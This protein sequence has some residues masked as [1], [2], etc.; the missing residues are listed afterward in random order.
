MPLHETAE[1]IHV[2]G[3]VQGVGF[4]PTVWRLAHRH[5]IRGTVSNDGQGVTIHACGPAAALDAL[6]EAIRREMPPLARIDSIERTAVTRMPPGPA[7]QIGPSQHDQV[8][9]G[10]V[11]DAATCTVCLAEVR[12][13]LE[14]RFGY[15]F[16]NCIHCG[17][18]LSI[19]ES[20]P[21]DR[22]GT[23]MRRFP[24]CG[25]CRA[26]YLDPGDRRFHAQPTACPVC[27][28]RAWLEP[29]RGAAFAFDDLAGLGSVHSLDSPDSPDSLSAGHAADTM[30]AACTVLLR[31]AVLAIKG[32]GGFQ[33]ACDATNE[34]AVARLRSVK[35]RASKPLALLARDLATIK[36]Y[37]HVDPA[38]AKL[39][40]SP[41][42]P[43]VILS[44]NDAVAAGLGLGLGLGLAP[45]CALAPAVAP[46]VRSLGFMLPSTPLHHLLLERIDRPIVLTSGN[47]SEEPQCIANDEARERLRDLTDYL[48]LHDRDIA[49]RL[50][51]SVARVMAGEVRV[52]R[53]ARGYAPAPLAL[54]PGFEATPPVLAM[55]GELKNT[56]CLVRRGQAIVSHHMG[57]LAE[58]RTH[59]DYVEAIG[60]Y[61]ELFAQPA[62][63]VAVDLHPEYRSRALGVALAKR[64]GAALLEVQHHHAHIA[65]CM[66]EN[67]VR[68]DAPAVLGIA[69]DGLGW[70]ADGTLWGGEFLLASYRECVRL[71]TLKPVAMPGGEL[72]IS[73]PWRNTFAHLMAQMGWARFAANYSTLDLYR[74]LS[75]K[76][77]QTL[78]L[79][80]ERGVNSPLASSC[81]RLFAGAAA[82]AGI[83]TEAAFYEGQAAVEFEN[84]VD[85]SALCHE[86]EAL[87][88]PFSIARRP[89]SEMP[90]IEPRAMW[91]A[92]L[93]DLKTR[94]PTGVIAA[95][96]HKGLA[97]AIVRMAARLCPIG[98]AGG[99]PATVALS[100]GVFQNRILL[101]QVAARLG[102]RGFRVLTHRQIPAGDGG[103]ALGQGVVAAARSLP[104]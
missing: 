58:L 48:L 39:L 86:D 50:D 72:A 46:G 98:A 104:L 25:A 5:G 28:P 30:D 42:A 31:G 21:Y 14:R 59:A 24:L 69:L 12:D 90:Y 6:V 10:V 52:L 73:E 1:L 9:T 19:I 102:A 7:F 100:G 74:V 103:L 33:L 75:T 87:A 79:M 77:W 62:C 65:A 43:I 96:F 18:R 17:P 3:L 82:A 44:R 51:D 68:L 4:R 49:R 35:G 101:E 55:G 70:G 71:A 91:Q 56:F 76:P 26:E 95:R 57:D 22:A 67:G 64:E 8:R 66:A 38:E 85:E 16:T 92:L 41:A 63:P 93:Q 20:I 83:C 88:Y 13:P 45:A 37:C 36:R 40:A 89:G 80:I 11:P 47:R 81:G 29:A 84:Q 54:P 99:C 27:G 97:I 78:G 60:A 32:L 15:P 23:T 61:R 53:R 2:Q 34:S 94:T